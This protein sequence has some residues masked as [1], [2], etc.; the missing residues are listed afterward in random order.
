M[1]FKNI[2]QSKLVQGIIIGIVVVIVLLSVFAVG[3][4]VGDRRAQ[5]VGN[6]GDKFDR[7]FR[8]PGMMDNNGGGMFGLDLKDDREMD[9]NSHGA[10]GQILTID[11]SKIVV[12]GSDNLEKIILINKNTLVREFQTEKNLQDLKVGDSIVVIGSPNGQGQIEAKLIRI[13][14]ADFMQKNI[15]NQA[16]T[17]RK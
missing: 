6:F 1:N 17:T 8:G 2:H 3:V 16:T 7:N 13:M 14:P 15:I 11:S 12:S 9:P 4:R 10:V 5:F